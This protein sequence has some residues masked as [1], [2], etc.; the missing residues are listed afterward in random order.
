LR[1]ETHAYL[2]GICKNLE[3]PSLQ[4]GG[5]IDYIHILCTLS[6]K[7]TISD[8]IRDLKRE[9]SKWIKTKDSLSLT[10]FSWQAGYGA[11][12]V[13]PSHLDTLRKY[14]VNQDTHHMKESFQ[15]EYRRLL[16]KYNIECDER[17]VW[18]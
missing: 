4:V 10:D 7:Y 8:L 9:S 14:I 12:S 11:F 6:R 2:S 15:D 5:A 13:S 17:Y 1:E 16:R 3:S 18:V